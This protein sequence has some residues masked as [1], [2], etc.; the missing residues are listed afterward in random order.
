[1]GHLE[2]G[3]FPGRDYC[4]GAKIQV[5]SVSSPLVFGSKLVT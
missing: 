2:M 4:V 1:M 5:R 3:V